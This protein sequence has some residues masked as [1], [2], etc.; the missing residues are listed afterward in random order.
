MGLDTKSYAGAL[1]SA[2]R[3]DPDVILIGE[4]RDKETIETAL[5]AAETGHLVLSTLHTMDATETINRII[6]TFEPYQQPQIRLQLAATLKSVVSQRLISR[7]DDSA[8][9]PAV[10]IM[11]VNTRI[12][13]MILDPKKTAEIPLAIEEGVDSYG[14][15][16]FDQS[17]MKLMVQGLIN[18]QE[19]LAAASNP[20]DFALRYKGVTSMDGKRWSGFDKTRVEGKP[21]EDTVKVEL[22]TIPG[23]KRKDGLPDD[24]PPDPPIK[25]KKN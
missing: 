25:K 15:Q 10:E 8:M 24:L 14:M 6:A 11:N 19:A 4:M 7:Q 23:I 21:A 22:R 3:Q 13:D 9:I 18:Y 20:A 5:L 2:L 17:L 12:R 1:R 16:S